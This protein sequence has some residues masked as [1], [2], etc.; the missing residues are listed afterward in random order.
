MA[1]DRFVN[2]SAQALKAFQTWSSNS[3][4]F[5]CKICHGHW[6]QFESFE[7]HL[8]TLHA[9]KA[10][11]YFIEKVFKFDER[12]GESNSTQAYETHNHA[13]VETKRE[14]CFETNE[15]SRHILGKAA[16]S[17]NPHC[18]SDAS[19]SKDVHTK[20]VA[21]PKIEDPREKAMSKYSTN[22]KTAFVS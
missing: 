21:S 16:K 8:H 7:L 9:T 6:K 10:F 18:G 13:K 1:R 22:V 20:R 14:S 19:A 3:A 15:V 4:E 11:I 12:L 2:A 5:K 17:E